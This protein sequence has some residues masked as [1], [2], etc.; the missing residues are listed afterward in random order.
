VKPS[1]ILLDE[2]GRPFLMDF[3]LARR[4]A[5]EVTMTVEG[6]VLGTPAY[7]SP[8]QARGDSHQ[9]DGRSDVYSLGVVLYQALTRRLPLR[10]PAPHDGPP[11]PTRRPPAAPQFRPGYSARPGN[12]LSQG[13]GEGA[14]PSLRLREGAGGRPAPLPRRRAHPGASSGCL[15]ARETLGPA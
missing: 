5:A 14:G 12:H 3:G 9:V 7:M 1:N 4:D 2:A 10:G 15:G 6:Q 13:D 8:E 11:V